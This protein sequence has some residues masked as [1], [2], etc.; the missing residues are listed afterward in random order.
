MSH[1]ELML[2]LEDQEMAAFGN[3]FGQQTGPKYFFK[4]LTYHYSYVSESSFCECLKHAGRVHSQKTL[5]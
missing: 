4:Q 5:F 1:V 3:V 2:S